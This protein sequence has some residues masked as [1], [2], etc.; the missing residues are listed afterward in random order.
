M[1]NLTRLAFGVAV[2]VGAFAGC[3][4]RDVS[5]LDVALEPALAP[6]VETGQLQLALTARGGSGAVYRLRQA[7]FDVFG[8]GPVFLQGA[9]LNSES[10]P[11]ATTLG[12]TLESGQYQ[13]T[14]FSSWFLEKVQNGRVDRVQARLLSPESQEFSI[15]ANE[16]TSVRY[17]FET[18]GELV[19]FGQGRLVVEIEVE[20]VPAAPDLTPGDPLEI[21]DGVIAPES[22]PFGLHAVLFSVT[23]AL[24]TELIVTEDT[25]R[26]CV[27]GSTEPVIDSDFA[28]RWGGL[29]GFQ[30]VAA[31][32]AEPDAGPP[33]LL[34]QPWDLGGGRV[35][36]FAF[37]ISG[38][39]IPPLRV[40]ALPGGADPSIDTFCLSL[41]PIPGAALQVPLSSL[42]RNCWEGLDSP[43]PTDSLASFSWMV[44]ADVGIGHV[45]D[46]CVSDVRPLLR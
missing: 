6:P 2:A 34:A 20:E 14:L 24:G 27:S 11:L 5:L 36:G 39:D 45:F 17:R 35:A 8:I 19:E 15:T 44:P 13:I 4:G 3:S 12:A 18:D 41:P 16:E 9:F 21:V 40:Q 37:T 29:F 31:E 1:A 32:P 10:D 26:L 28:N 30:F 25:G 22:N 42:D 23:S 43:M 7:Q 46:F 33:P 38:A